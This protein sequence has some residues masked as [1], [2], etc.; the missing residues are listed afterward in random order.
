MKYLNKQTTYAKVFSWRIHWLYCDLSHSEELKNLTSSESSIQNAIALLNK[1]SQNFNRLIWEIETILD[2]YSEDVLEELKT[3][4]E[5][6]RYKDEYQFFAN[7][8]IEF[9]QQNM[10][11]NL[12]TIREQLTNNSIN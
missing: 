5:Y 1:N 4:E 3:M 10:E 12:K 7:R 11:N 8:I 2:C 6:I 9:T